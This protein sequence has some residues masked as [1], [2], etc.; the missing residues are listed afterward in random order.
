MGPLSVELVIHK[1]Q[2]SLLEMCVNDRNRTEVAKRTRMEVPN[3][4]TID[5]N[6]VYYDKTQRANFPGKPFLS[7]YKTA[8]KR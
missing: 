8:L 5:K 3:T 7:S 2:S 6:A 4:K 1:C